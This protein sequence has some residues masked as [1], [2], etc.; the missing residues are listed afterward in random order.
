LPLLGEQPAQRLSREFI[1]V[2]TASL[3]CQL[4]HLLPREMQEL[5]RL[6]RLH[7][8]DSACAKKTPLLQQA[9]GRQLSGNR[10]SHSSSRKQAVVTTHSS[11]ACRSQQRAVLRDSSPLRLILSKSTAT[12]VTS[13]ECW[14][15]LPS[16]RCFGPGLCAA[17]QP[18]RSEKGR[19]NSP[20]IGGRTGGTRIG[21]AQAT[22][23]PRASIRTRGSPFVS[24]PVSSMLP[25]FNTSG[26]HL[27][28]C[29]R[30]AAAN[31]RRAGAR[32][33]QDR[34]SNAGAQA[35]QENRE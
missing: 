32:G 22:W 5:L 30:L 7:A 17:P 33:H 9:R 28:A 4:M 26:F 14:I 25:S 27:Q 21:H 16:S 35:R 20:E 23:A 19:A 8:A 10:E 29:F 34:Q 13:T 18:P 15:Q 1:Q 3:P 12:R 6:V 11:S 31:Q 2:V 24:R